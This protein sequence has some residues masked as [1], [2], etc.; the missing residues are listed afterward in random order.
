M[1]VFKGLHHVAISV[2]SLKAAKE[3]DVEKVGMTIADEAIAQHLRKQDKKIFIVANKIDGTDAD[4]V[5]AEFYALALGEVYQ[6]AAAHGKGVRQMIDVALDGFFDD[7]EDW[8]IKFY[9]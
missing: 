4:S 7:V 9:P 3:F 2:P 5:C 6:I 8:L 1:F